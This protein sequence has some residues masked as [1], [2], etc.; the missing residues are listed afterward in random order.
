M[1]C[2]CNPKI[3][4]YQGRTLLH[5]ACGIGNV[6][7]IT[8]LIEKYR[9]SP[10]ATDAVNQTLLH[11]AASHGQEEALRLL[12]TDYNMAVDCRSSHKLSPLHLACY[13]GHVSVVKMLLL[14][15]KA[16]LN[17][18]DESGSTP[19]LKVTLG[20]NSVL[21]QLMITHFNQ[22]PL[23]TY[24][25]S[26][27][28]PLHMACWGGHEELARLLITNYNC[29]VDIKNKNNET[30]LHKACSS[31]HSSIV[32]ILVYEFKA[33]TTQRDHNNDTAVSI[34]AEEGHVEIMQAL[35]TE[36]GCSPKV[37]G[38]DGR[39]LL[40][41]ACR[42]G[43]IKLAEMLIIDF[44]LDILSADDSGNTPLHMACLGGHEELAR[45]LITKYYCPFDVV[46]KNNHTPLHN[47]YWAGHSPIVKMLLSEFKANLMAFDRANDIPIDKAAVN[48]H[49][50]TV[51]VLITELGCSP[52]VEG[53]EGRSLLHQACVKGHTKLVINLITDLNL[54]LLS[55]DN[56][57]DTPLHMACRCGHEELARVLITKYNCPV[58]V[59]NWMNK[60]PLHLACSFGHTGV[61]R[62]LISEFK[63]NKYY[64]HN[65]Q[66]DSVIGEA[67]LAGH[68]SIVQVLVTE[69]SCS[70]QVKG[71]KGRSLLHYACV[72]GHTELAMTSITD[73]KLDPHSADD[74]G[75]TPLHLA[76][77]GGHEELARLLITKY[78]C[79][80]DVVNKKN[81]TP[82]HNACWVGHF[83]IIKMLVSMA[84]ANQMACDHENDTP[85]NKAALNG[86]EDTVQMLITELGC[87][88]QTKGF[89]GRSLLH[90]ACAK[91]HTKLVMILITEYGLDPLSVDDKSNTYLHIACSGGHEELARLLI[92]NYNCPIDVKNKI[93][94][95]PLHKACSSGHSS[96]VKILVTEFKAD[97]T[98][99]DHID[100]TAVSKAAEGGHVETVHA[101][102]TELGCS[103]KITGY[104]GRSLLHE[105][106]WSG[107]IKLAEML[108]I[109]FSLDVLSADD[110]GNTP[111]HM[112]FWGGHEK[113]ARLL[114][115][116][117]N[118]ASNVLISECMLEDDKRFCNAQDKGNDTPLDLLIKR[119][120]AKAVHILSTKY[121]CKP[122]V[123]GVESKPLLHQLAAG[124]FTTMLQELI[125]KFHYDPVCPDEGGNT[126][127]HTA[128]QHGKC[129]IAEFLIF[130]Y[131][132]QF[133][134]DYRNCRGLTALHHACIYGHARI[135]KL[136]ASKALGDKDVKALVDDCG[137]T[138][139]HI[140]AQHGRYESTKLL[141]AH[142]SHQCPVDHRNS[143]G[144]TALHC[145]CIGG[146]TMVAKFLVANKADITVRDEDDD[147]PLKKAFLKR[148]IY[149][150]F[151]LF[152]SK[153]QT[154]DHKLLLQVCERGSINLIDVLLSDFHLD[155]SL[156]LDDQGNKAIH[157]AALQGHKQVVTL[158]VKKYNC[159]IDVKN[160]VKQTPLHMACSRGHLDVSKVLISECMLD[161]D[162]RFNN[163]LDKNN[164]TPLDLLIKKG[165]ATGVH[166]L[167]HY[168]CKPN[169][170]G[171]ESKP[172]LHQ[173]AAGGFTTMLQELISWFNYDPACLD[174]DG[175][176]ILHIAAQHGQY[177]IAEFVITWNQFP[178]DHRNC[179]GLTALHCACMCCHTR[180][181]VLIA[182]KALGDKNEKAFVDDCGNTL[183]HIAAQ[184]GRYEIAKLLLADYGNQC[185]IDYRN[186]QG[187]TALHCACI[188]GH[189][190][191]AKFL[192][193][194]KADITIRDENGDTPFKK[195]F[196]K[197]HEHTLF[198]LFDSN[199]DTIEHNILLQVCERRFL[200]F[201]ERSLLHHALA[202]GHTST[203]KT[204][205]EDFHLSL[206]CVDEDGNA[207]LHL[208]SLF[209][210]TH[211]VRFLLYE[212]HAPVYIRNK[213]GKIALDLAV[214]DSTK[215]VIREYVK[216]EYKRI[217]REYDKLRAKSLQKYS[218]QQ[219]ITRVFVLGNPGS[220]KSTL[221]ESLKRK[222]FFYLLNVPEADV[223]LHTAGI[224]PSASQSSAGRVLYYDFAGDQEYYSSHAA[225]LEM[226]S[227]STV[228]SNVFLIVAD[229]TKDDAILQ[230]EIGYWLSFISYHGKA[231]DSQCKLKVIVVL[232]HLDRL[233]V[234]EFDNKVDSARQ[235]LQTHI[236]QYNEVKF[237]VEIV[238]LNCRSPRSSKSIE[239][240]LQQISKDTPPC[241]ISYEASLLHGILEKDFGNVVA[242]K[243]Q[244][245]LSNIEEIGIYLPS[246]A[247]A[248]HPIVRELH[249]IGLLM[250]IGRNE[251]ELEN[252][253]LLLNPSS[254]TNE[255]HE[256]LFSSSAVKKLE[257]SIG[258]HYANMGIL[259]ENYI[260][261][262]LPEHITKECLVQLQY[263][264]EFNHAEVGLDYS[265]TS[266]DASDNNLLYFPALCK[267]DS[268]K[269]GWSND[270]KFT[271]SI[272]WYAECTEKFDYF[273]A[274]FLHV[275]LLR[276]AYAFA[277]PIVNRNSTNSS[278]EVSAYSRR[279][280]MWKNG[281]H[282]RMEEGVEYIV[283]IVNDNKGIVVITKYK[284]NS[285]KWASVLGKII[286]KAMQAK[287]E[288]CNA[289]S[290]NHF[291]L[292]SKSDDTSSYSD[293]K[294][295][296]CIHDIER[297]IR[298]LRDDPDLEVL[299]AD[300]R[301]SNSL[302]SHILYILKRYSC[303]GKL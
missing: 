15:Y 212:Y 6:K 261:S 149:T 94:E 88:P 263:C 13:C 154:I 281:I 214:K 158:L 153:L 60:T 180:I 91:G 179:R 61:V 279:C 278:N 249:D 47:A 221:V 17:A 106:C 258:P 267:L 155:P 147:T 140:A 192:V 166:I 32:G 144:Q 148:Q 265:V 135:A 194:I 66:N 156:V 142:Y 105:A 124:G 231:L 236:N 89:E 235:C 222:G 23:S 286:D 76:C 254:L 68:L 121:G 190:R 107:S 207:P 42:S 243:F 2:A 253:L 246:S 130:N 84:K 116:K 100:D 159:P 58:D 157:I 8:T 294:N 183:L 225:I 57:G 44:S 266:D 242:C 73:F 102:L 112:A 59:M 244:R 67:V 146:H 152:D 241:S 165:D 181:V 210:Q 168:G 34:A 216:S 77:L 62:M 229:L 151:A 197:G 20:G 299:S 137:N 16:D 65:Y 163:A 86:H 14:E 39:S 200:G 218:G 276:L 119:G 259:P 282:W 21:I 93:K 45:L 64:V 256:K 280:T 36:L 264:Q 111:L 98:Q 113:L 55:T 298:Q 215:K 160:E 40:H 29:P 3:K 226:V 186:S 247:D 35:I 230:D 127:L 245:L 95:T 176:T 195:A 164:N 213:A 134:I 52:Q 80:A 87:N 219:I 189:T 234:A 289:V 217:Q 295:L 162:K 188:G 109:D 117:Y 274:R 199:L 51:Q 99:R 27:N 63:A 174:E 37:T 56:N 277:L 18:R 290:L 293:P 81:R 271:F 24:N 75:D 232:S 70:P 303:W 53:Y 251:D 208:S 285:E 206:H 38:Y 240:I 248:L 7:L 133:P 238:S 108:I 301:G 283:E 83:P 41:E 78:N 31:G 123:R 48:R 19:F 11:I 257:S 138:L 143:Q 5:F 122:N 182:N 115:T 12:I 201:K 129:E 85:I 25:D 198:E 167:S 30:P 120:D 110:S 10:M 191:V 173:L 82:L 268:K 33:D 184:H 255:V 22:N 132:N 178:I 209:G 26:G 272:G 72:K 302:D 69:F 296:F 223:P 193:A 79:S 54:D 139:L 136:I 250:L 270:P 177:E 175:N 273:P 90:Q 92:T 9:I 252:Y 204:L 49:T 227:R 287:A 291:V 50:G 96:I 275:L 205:I 1:F 145:A 300:R 4:G 262:I 169:V 43:N 172:L 46:N 161:G 220:G 187:Q 239:N 237:D 101:L 118:Y 297:V 228:G 141:F 131:R 202:K 211:S 28:T 260:A 150:L 97:A 74:S 288:F 71:F 269:S 170:R 103:P 203:A 104:N 185:P 292:K 128:A 284:E 233:D 114:I 125:S 126:I 171:V 196:L 224:I